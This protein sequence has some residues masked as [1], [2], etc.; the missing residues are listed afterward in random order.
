MESAKA[1]RTL[2]V[3]EGRQENKKVVDDFKKAAEDR[4]WGFSQLDGLNS[5]RLA[6]FDLSDIPLDY[7]R[8]YQRP[9]RLARYRKDILD[10]RCRSAVYPC[11]KPRR[12][13]RFYDEHDVLYLPR[14]SLRACR[15]LKLG[16]Y[17]SEDKSGRVG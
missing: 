6:R 14:A 15:R 16:D 12:L 13:R 4:G 10:T 8:I 11:D 17:R 2:T 5:D 7:R 9:L 1:H 3:V